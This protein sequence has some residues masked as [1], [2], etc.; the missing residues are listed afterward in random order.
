MIY[1]QYHYSFCSLN[2]SDKTAIF[3]PVIGFGMSDNAESTNASLGIALKVLVIVIHFK[4]SCERM[5]KD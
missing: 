1:K 4:Y 3:S 2:S 5:I